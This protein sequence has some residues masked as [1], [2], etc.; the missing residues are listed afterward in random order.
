MQIVDTSLIFK[1]PCVDLEANTLKTQ[2]SEFYE[3]WLANFGPFFSNLGLLKARSPSNLVMNNSWCRPILPHSIS[4]FLDC[5]L[6][7]RTFTALPYLENNSPQVLLDWISF[8]LNAF[9]EKWTQSTFSCKSLSLKAVR[10]V[11]MLVFSVRHH[12]AKTFVNVHNTYV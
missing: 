3:A 11:M 6:N 7:P 1:T 2:K 9:A 12:T 4:S 10:E 5:P 8:R